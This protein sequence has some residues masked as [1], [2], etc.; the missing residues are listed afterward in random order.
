MRRG[1][2]S[3]HLDEVHLNVEPIES[4]E[5]RITFVTRVAGKLTWAVT[6]LIA[7]ELVLSIALHQLLVALEY[8]SIINKYENG[9]KGEES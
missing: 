2:W 1:A 3:L 6:A 5:T 4:S 8:R 7:P 9:G